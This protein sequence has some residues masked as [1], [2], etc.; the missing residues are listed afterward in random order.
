[1][2]NGNEYGEGGCMQPNGGLRVGFA[3]RTT[4]VAVGVDRTCYAVGKVVTNRAEGT[5]CSR[6]SAT[7]LL[8]NHPILPSFHEFVRASG[9]QLPGSTP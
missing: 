9:A 2:T 7:G 6:S 5:Q 8:S 3:T 1:M 4:P